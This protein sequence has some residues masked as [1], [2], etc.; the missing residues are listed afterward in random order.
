M[1]ASPSRGNVSYEL[2]QPR[3]MYLIYNIPKRDLMRHFFLSCCARWDEYLSNSFFQTR[4]SIS[5]AFKL[6][7]EEQ[8][9]VQHHRFDSMKRDFVIGSRKPLLGKRFRYA[10]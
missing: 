8:R 2:H 1:H 10:R 3:G 7:P 6:V 4:S 5:I 9:L